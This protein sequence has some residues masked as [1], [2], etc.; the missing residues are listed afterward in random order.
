MATSF[1]GG[2]FFGGEFF[3]SATP[4]VVGG[5]FAGRKKRKHGNPDAERI[6]ARARLRAQILDALDGPKELRAV[7]AEV[8]APYVEQP[9]RAPDAPTA[10]PPSAS[11]AD[12][13]YIGARELPKRIDWARVELDFE[14]LQMRLRQA[15]QDDIDEDALLIDDSVDD[16]EDAEDWKLLN[17]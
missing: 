1:F 16:D 15:I 17:G 8:I 3:F 14:F 2:A 11:P 12:W 7:V 13:A 5:H 9:I 6:A 4:A 10:D